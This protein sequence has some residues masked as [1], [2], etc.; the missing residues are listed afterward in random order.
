M[1]KM[2]AALVSTLVYSVVPVVLSWLFLSYAAMQMVYWSL[3]LV[4]GTPI[5]QPLLRVV[6]ADLYITV[7]GELKPRGPE[8][9][10]LP[11]S[12]RRMKA[13]SSKLRHIFF[14]RA[15]FGNI[16][17]L[18]RILFERYYSKQK[19]KQPLYVV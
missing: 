7:T 17:F 12:S 16:E 13:L 9:D 4:M 8:F 11:E 18:D 1:G 14:W 6:L 2:M 15:F 19:I 3:V 10:H 5:G